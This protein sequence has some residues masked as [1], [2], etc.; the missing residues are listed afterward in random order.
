MHAEAL[1]KQLHKRLGGTWT[2]LIRLHPNAREHEA[3]VLKTNPGAVGV[4]N[5]P[6]LSALIMTADLVV[7]DFSSVMFDSLYADRPTFILAQD[8]D[9]YVNGERGVYDIIHKLPFTVTKTPEAL[10]SSINQFSPDE[11]T[12]KRQA[13]LNLI[14]DHES[15]ES[16]VLL[17]KH[18]VAKMKGETVDDA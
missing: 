6:D 4:T 8:Y 9:D 16:A 17:A 7:T 5:F 1:R 14:G 3:E 13:F 18:V 12:H 15:G 10:I 11:Y 2:I